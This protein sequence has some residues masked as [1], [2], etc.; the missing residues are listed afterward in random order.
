MRVSQVLDSMKIYFALSL[1]DGLVHRNLGLQHDSERKMSLREWTA[2]LGSWHLLRSNCGGERDGAF[3]DSWGMVLRYYHQL[4]NSDISKHFPFHLV[5]NLTVSPTSS[6]A[7]IPETS[8][9]KNTQIAMSVVAHALNKQ[10]I[11]NMLHRLVCTR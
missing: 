10:M 8:E 5:D 1:E 4:F 3:K 11:L 9:T 6:T 7:Q 2:F